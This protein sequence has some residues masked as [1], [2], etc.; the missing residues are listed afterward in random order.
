M[1]ASGYIS[2]LMVLLRS[3]DQPE[4]NVQCSVVQFGK[5]SLNKGQKVEEGITRWQ[6][7]TEIRVF[8]IR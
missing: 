7:I 4:C 8:D 2:V 1:I 5:K 6:K 3:N